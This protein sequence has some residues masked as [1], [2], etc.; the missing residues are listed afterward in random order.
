MPATQPMKG[1]DVLVRAGALPAQ[2]YDEIVELVSDGTTRSED[3]LVD[4]DILD[5]AALLSGLSQAY[6][7]HFVSSEK[8]AKLEIAKSTLQTIP[9]RVA[10]L[11]CVFPV[12]FDPQSGTLSVVTPDPDDASMLS[13][14]R[15]L[16]GAREVKAFVARPASV[17]AAI[18]KHHLGETFAFSG[19][20]PKAAAAMYDAN[21][22]LPS[23]KLSGVAGGARA[24]DVPTPALTVAAKPR[25]ELEAPEAPRAAA[26]PPPPTPTGNRVHALLEVTARLLDAHRGELRGHSAIVAKLVSR[27]AETAGLGT[28][29]VQ[30]LFAAGLAHDLGKPG[31]IHVTALS[32]TLENVKPI[33]LRAAM[34]PGQLLEAV[35]LSETTK[36]AML[37]MYERWDGL[38]GPSRAAGTAI[39]EGARLLAVA[40]AYA[41]LVKNPE[42]PYGRLLT[43]QEAL[44]I[45][46]KAAGTLFDPSAITLLAQ[47]L[48]E[49]SLL[50]RVQGLVAGKKTGK[51][52]LVGAEGRAE[53]WFLAGACVHASCDGAM[54]GGLELYGSPAFYA[55]VAMGDADASFD[56][57]A[58]P[59]QRSISEGT[60]ELLAAAANR[61]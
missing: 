43:P 10:E 25:R 41:D 44:T 38:G 28:E 13:E 33:V 19:L 21:V 46:T 4:A 24:Q 52:V 42:N 16:S 2:R 34:V 23:G 61:R 22:L 58:P 9:R 55:A 20:G 56:A 27:M 17:R 18:R 40:D 45:L 5:E 15:V 7:V 53:V 31:E 6:R 11:L 1:A 50:E 47:S 49:P 12:M 59:K 35:G 37:H 26:G 39:P 54:A 36:L 8:L 51:L 60:T 57:S 32:A 14:V 30:A 3:A 48:R 29:E